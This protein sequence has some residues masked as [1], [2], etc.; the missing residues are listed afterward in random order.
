M[1]T[2]PATARHAHEHTR[3]PGCTGNKAGRPARLHKIE[4]QRCGIAR[5]VTGDRSCI[6]VL[7][8]SSAADRAPQEVAPS[9]LDD[10]VRGCVT[11]AARTGPARA[12]EKHAELTDALHRALRL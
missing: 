7:P 4:S 11:D 3:A 10:H 1:A 5:M 2:A 9:L 8:Q 12:E 6:D